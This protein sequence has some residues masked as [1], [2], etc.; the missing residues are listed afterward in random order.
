M[1]HTPPL[2]PARHN[3]TRRLRARLL[4]LFT[5]ILYL[6]A[7][8]CSGLRTRWVCTA[9]GLAW[10]LAAMLWL[11]SRWAGRP[12]HLLAWHAIAPLHGA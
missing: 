7:G 12:L 10:A 4:T 3:L 9:S 5:S 11:L 6:P 2:L 8:T 1:P